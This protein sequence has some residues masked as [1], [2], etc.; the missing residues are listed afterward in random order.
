MRMLRPTSAALLCFPILLAG[1]SLLPTTRKLPVPRPPTIT[2]TIAPEE[3][4]DL[5]NKRWAAINTLTLKTGFRATTSKDGVATDYPS[6]DGNILIRKP[7]DLHVLG[8]F[9][10]SRVFD[11]VGDA[12]DFTLSIPP[13]NLVIRGRNSVVNKSKNTWE[14]LRPGFFLDS[15]LV[16]GLEKDDHYSVTSET[17]IVEDAVRKHLY[18]VPEYILRITHDKEGTQQETLV[19]V[20]YFHRDDLQPC[21]QDIYDSEGK[22][23]TQVLYG[24][25]HQFDATMFP[26]SI[27]IKRPNENLQVVLTVEDLHLNVPLNDGQFVVSKPAADATIQVLE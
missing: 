22:L 15:I 19:R 21:Q 12:T 10:G 8:R 26:L 11:M 13:K 14:N 9:F 27:T 1:C 5:L 25:Y 2:H 23:E 3:L 20:L 24:P 6:A 16:P 7:S 17:F 4:V 18:S